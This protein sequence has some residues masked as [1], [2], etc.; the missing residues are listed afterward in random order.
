MCWETFTSPRLL[1]GLGTVGVWKFILSFKVKE[2]VL[3]IC[4]LYDMFVLHIVLLF[5]PTLKMF[6]G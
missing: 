6:F 5:C 4:I 3:G 2:Q 1:V